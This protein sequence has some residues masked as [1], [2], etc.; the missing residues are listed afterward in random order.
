MWEMWFSLCII[1]LLLWIQRNPKKQGISMLEALIGKEGVLTIPIG[2]TLLDS[3]RMRINGDEW[4]VRSISGA[5]ITSGT[6]VTIKRIEG[7]YLIVEPN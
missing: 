6:P 1:I 3:G 7:I 5:P 2:T 4:C